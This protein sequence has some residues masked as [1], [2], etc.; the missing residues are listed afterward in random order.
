MR[1]IRF[2][3]C[4]RVVERSLRIVQK[5]LRRTTLRSGP[6]SAEGIACWFIDTDYKTESFF[7]RHIYAKPGRNPV[8][9]KVIDIFGNNTMTLVPV[10]AG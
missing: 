3:P 4:L 10:N 8:A 5:T 9:V 1:A 6:P 7:V 2:R